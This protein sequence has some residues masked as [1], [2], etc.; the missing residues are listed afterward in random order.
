MEVVE[1]RYSFLSWF[2]IL[3]FYFYLLSD[4]LNRFFI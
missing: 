3:Y 1:K 4:E 2:R